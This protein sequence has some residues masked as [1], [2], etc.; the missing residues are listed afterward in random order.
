MTGCAAGATPGAR[1]SNAPEGLEQSQRDVSIGRILPRNDRHFLAQ[2]RQIERPIDQEQHGAGLAAAPE[3]RREQPDGESKP[4]EKLQ[5]FE[6][7]NGALQIQSCARP[8]GEQRLVLAPHSGLAA[9]GVNGDQAEQRVQIEMREGARMRAQAQIALEN[10]GWDA[11]GMARA[12]NAAR[13]AMGALAGSIQMMPAM[14]NTISK[15]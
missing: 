5:R 3:V 12:A 13:I 4:R 9:V 15:L 1:C 8:F 14:V 7:K 6:R 10:R 2:R 11:S